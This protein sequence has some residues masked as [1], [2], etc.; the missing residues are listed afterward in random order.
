MPLL[1]ASQKENL[2]LLCV[3]AWSKPK[4]QGVA[5]AGQEHNKGNQPW[6]QAGRRMD[7]CWVSHYMEKFTWLSCSLEPQRRTTVFPWEIILRAPRMCVL[8]LRS[9]EHHVL[10]HPGFF[11]LGVKMQ[12][13]PWMQSCCCSVG[14]EKEAS[15]SFPQP[16]P[17][18][19]PQDPFC[20]TLQPLDLSLILQS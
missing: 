11:N 4:A 13:I 17:V 19:F 10:I 3:C 1:G 12:S 6:K 20:R 7:S 8:F 5:Q 9:E 2:S 18:I 15:V 16:Q 14:R